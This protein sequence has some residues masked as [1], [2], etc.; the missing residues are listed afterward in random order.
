MD[1]K[2]ASYKDPVASPKKGKGGP[3]LNQLHPMKKNKNSSHP[4]NTMEFQCV[5]VL[6]Q[7]GASFSPESPC[8]D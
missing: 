6:R 2:K 8:Y 3:Q 1:G 5:K 4:K 7:G